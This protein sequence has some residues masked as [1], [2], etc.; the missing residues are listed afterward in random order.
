ME[1]KYDAIIFYEELPPDRQ[2]ALQAALEEDPELARA[3]AQWRRVRAAVRERMDTY[4]PDRR[5][6]VLYAL[7]EAGRSDMLDA[8]EC[9]ALDEARPAIEQ[10]L[11]R[12]PGL[13]A[14]VERIQKDSTAFE[15]AWTAQFA[16]ETAPEKLRAD[17]P[18]QRSRAQRSSFAARRWM[19]RL[20]VVA[21]AVLIAVFSVVFFTQPDER[22][23]VT[24]GPD[25]VRQVELE[26]GS[27]VRLMAEAQ[28]AYDAS[29]FD[30]AVTL[31][32]GHAFFEVASASRPF[33]VETPTARTTALGTSFGVQVEATATQVVLADGEVEVA[34]LR[35]LEEAVRLQPGQASRVA[36]EEM[37]TAPTSVDVMDAL[38]WTGLFVFRDTPMEEIAERLER[39]YEAT[40]AVAPSMRD[41]AVTG[42]FEQDQPLSEILETVAAT[43]DA[44]VVTT[45]DGY[46]IEEEAT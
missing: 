24:T 36:E 2:K 20:G 11:D 33:V 44:Q 18:P 16:E 4:I 30:R 12:Y 45:E 31:E 37:P 34:S 14:A 21:A 9:E 40:I 26:D 3:F 38:A 13:E 29:A 27:T 22:V 28:L 41:E 42:T 46:R 25:E 19:W 17:R 10:A 43:L 5:L 7:D 8:D 39:H 32:D 15:A 35:A 23:V 6:L 1:D